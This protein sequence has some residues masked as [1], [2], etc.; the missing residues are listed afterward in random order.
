MHAQGGV[1]ALVAVYMLGPRLGRFNA[2]GQVVG[3]HSI[4]ARPGPA[5]LLLNRNCPTRF[6]HPEPSPPTLRAPAACGR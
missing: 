5:A 1:A 6:F 2:K 4:E 3:L